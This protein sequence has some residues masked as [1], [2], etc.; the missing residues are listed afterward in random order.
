MENGMNQDDDR[1]N[2]VCFVE[3]PDEKAQIASDILYQLPEW[4]GLPESTKTYIEDSKEMP[5]WAYFVQ[6]KAIGFLALKETSTY[7]AE[8]YVMGVIKEYHRNGTG[9]LLLRECEAY[10]VQS[11]YEFLQVKTVQK[12]RYEEYDRTNVFYE[13]MGFRE[14]EC[15]KTLWDEWNPCQVY[16][17]TVANLSA[18]SGK[19]ESYDCKS[20]H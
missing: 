12:G 10:A 1:Q 4:F 7:T 14:L 6:G 9:A 19:G 11:G 15:F 17:K 3:N 13:R 20:G 8:V 18:N 16:V 5:F 2:A